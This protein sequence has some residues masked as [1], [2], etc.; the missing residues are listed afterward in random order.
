L[1][2]WTEKEIKYLKQ[3]YDKMDYY[4][5]ARNLGRSYKSVQAKINRIGL[6]KIVYWTDDEVNY[7]VKNFSTASWDEMIKY[8]NKSKSAIKHKANRY[9][10]TREENWSDSEK[11]LLKQKYATTTFKDL[12]NIFNKSRRTISKK[13][14]SLGLKKYRIY[15]IRRIYHIDHDYFSTID[16]EGKA[17]Y[18]GLIATDGCVRDNI[19]VLE[20]SNKIED[21]DIF[22]KFLK[23][24]KSD[25][26][27][28]E[29]KNNVNFSIT[30]KPIIDDLM[31]LGITPRKTFTVKYPDIPENLNRHFI[32]GVFDGDGSIAIGGTKNTAKFRFKIVSASK[33]F[34]DGLYEEIKKVTDLTAKLYRYKNM[35]EI[36]TAKKQNLVDLYY[37]LYK[38]ANFYLQ[39]KKDRFDSF[40]KSQNLELV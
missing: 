37:Y 40:I 23:E 3:N 10:L 19:N 8:L 17:Y 16:S 27:L 31:K 6:T 2:D 13:A 21:K 35:Y 11:E 32:R 12:E 26:K 34:I 20:F 39:R 24:L 14:K 18:L 9:G 22:E 7:L 30:S 29:Y 5:I 28:R 15:H 38:D 25:Y 36:S 4:E 33:D 1:T